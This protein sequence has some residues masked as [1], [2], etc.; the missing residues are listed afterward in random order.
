MRRLLIASLLAIVSA[1]AASAADAPLIVT[2]TDADTS[3]VNSVYFQLLGGYVAAGEVSFNDGGDVYDTVAGWGIAGTV[4]VVVMDGLSVEAD[5]LH[6]RRAET[7]APYEYYT[8][9]LM[10]N[11]KYTAEL[12]EMFSLYAAAGLGYI[13][14]IEHYIPT[15]EEWT[16][17][18]FGYQ[19]I[20][21]ASAQVTDNIALIGEARFQN[22]FGEAEGDGFSLGVPTTAV[23]FG[24]KVSFD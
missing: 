4:G 14:N 21:G 13:W 5:V 6:T 19:V 1:T 8:T 12:N 17:S 11:L 10:A 16:A 18:G 23:L 22:T 9:S 24:A 2:E 20:V 15:G 3:F 7:P